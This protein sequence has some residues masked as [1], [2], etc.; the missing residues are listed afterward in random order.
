MYSIQFI[1]YHVKEYISEYL[2]FF[3][4]KSESVFGDQQL[5]TLP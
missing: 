3:L 5:Y 2:L 4:K 1:L